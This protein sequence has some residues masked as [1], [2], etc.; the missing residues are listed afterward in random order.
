M[1]PRPWTVLPH[2]PLEDHQPNLKSVEGELPRGNVKRR[3]SVARLADGRLAFFNG[4][5]LRE[6]E[7]QKLETWGTPSIL[8]IPNGF[9][10]LDIH[11]FKERYPQLQVFCP[12]GVRARIAEVVA[13][14][15]AI[16]DLPR[17]QGIEW[18]SLRGTKPG[19][20]AMLVRDGPT[21]SLCFGDAIMNLPH[22]P[23][24]DGFLFRLIRSTGTPKVTPLAQ[25]TL[26]EN[27]PALA[28]HLRELSASPGLNRLVP[29][30][31]NVVEN[32]APGVLRRAADS[33]HATS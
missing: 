2:G 25:F 20:M 17:N 15:G 11:A 3:M 31:G 4:I 16:E 33:L 23:G 8:C 9:H 30:H 18:I 14:D 27:K 13:V 22:L 19:E 21:S 26:V 6:T 29:S 10:R 32:D 12:K 28:D 24:L 7:M 1:P 5:P